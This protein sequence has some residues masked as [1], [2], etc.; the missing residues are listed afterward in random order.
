[1]VLVGV[2]DHESAAAYAIIGSWKALEAPLIRN[3]VR[4]ARAAVSLGCD[5]PQRR[6][7]TA[8]SIAFDATSSPPFARPAVSTERSLG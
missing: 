3:S 2:A 6:A 7:G 1:M 5:L 4:R 8:A